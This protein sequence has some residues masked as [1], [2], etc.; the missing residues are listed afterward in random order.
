[1]WVRRVVIT[2]LLL[3]GLPLL[4]VGAGFALLEAWNRADAGG[5]ESLGTPPEALEAMVDA[6]LDAVY[7]R[8]VDGSLF[9]CDRTGPTRDNACWQEIAELPEREAGVDHRDTYGKEIP[10][11]PGRVVESIDV[12]RMFAE[13]SSHA[14]YALLEDG[15]IWHWDYNG[16]ANWSLLLLASGPVCGLALAIVIVLVMWLGAGLRALLAAAKRKRAADAM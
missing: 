7:A 6:S 11:P 12:S 10:A 2:I 8:A 9:A 5:W 14:R 15:S 4:G 16:D 1:M 3:I 13:R